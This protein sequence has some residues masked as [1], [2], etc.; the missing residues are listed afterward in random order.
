M[1]SLRVTVHFCQPLKNTDLRLGPQCFLR[2]DKMH[3]HPQR[4]HYLY[5]I[6]LKYFVKFVKKYTRCVLI[7]MLTATIYLCADKDGK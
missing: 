5:N 7:K 1:T 2:I 4:G 6:T 3:C